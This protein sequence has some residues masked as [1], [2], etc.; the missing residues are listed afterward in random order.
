MIIVIHH[1]GGMAQTRLR[2]TDVDSYKIGVDDHLLVVKLYLF[3]C[4]MRSVPVLGPFDEI[5][6]H[7]SRGP[8]M[9]FES[10]T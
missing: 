9:C 5:G 6:L 1:H 3:F 8:S 7:T 4:Q 2:T 10:R